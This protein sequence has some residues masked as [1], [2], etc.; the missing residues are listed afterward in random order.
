MVLF[1]AA[2][3]WRI[4]IWSKLRE[5]KAFVL[6][7]NIA[8]LKSHIFA[9]KM[10]K[11]LIDWHFCCLGFLP[12]RFW[13]GGFQCFHTSIKCLSRCTSIKSKLRFSRSCRRRERRK[14]WRYSEK[15]CDKYVAHIA[16]T[17]AW[18]SWHY[19]TWNPLRNPLHFEQSANRTDR[20]RRRRDRRKF[21]IF[22]TK[23]PV[24]APVFQRKR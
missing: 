12:S 14:I 11:T 3:P 2:L 9:L 7:N 10:V 20:E 22:W 8:S 17:F 16:D 13:L 1:G 6:F 19:K 23:I 4:F 15:N 18:W 21:G 5:R 24:K